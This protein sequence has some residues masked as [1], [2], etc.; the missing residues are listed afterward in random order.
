M[1]LVGTSGLLYLKGRSDTEPAEQRMVTMD[2][3]FLVALLLTSLTGLL[4]LALRE[5]GAMGIL[6]VIHLG[7]VAA[8]FITLPYGKFAHLFYRYAALIRNSLE[9]RADA[10]PARAGH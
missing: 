1:L 10:D 5:T 8:L 3:A 6:L 4:L 2:I 9:E 7:V